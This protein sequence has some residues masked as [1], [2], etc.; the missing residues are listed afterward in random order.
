[1]TTKIKKYLRVIS[2]GLV[3]VFA[4]AL[5]VPAA[6][7][8]KDITSDPLKLLNDV[9]NKSGKTSTRTLPEVI[10]QIIQWVLGIVG[11]VLLV[12]FIYG[13]VLY[14]TSAGNED[15]TETAKKVMLYAIIGVIIIALAFVLTRYI[16]QALFVSV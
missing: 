11:V 1:M 15:K 5:L 12:M 3:G 13:G 16:I 10:G 7:D 6:V 4:L 14:A 8:A 9:G 2:I